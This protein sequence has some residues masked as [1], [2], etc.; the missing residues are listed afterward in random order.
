MTEMQLCYSLLWALQP[1]GSWGLQSYPMLRVSLSL[2]LSPASGLCS[3]HRAL[4]CQ[5]SAIY[6]VFP[7]LSPKTAIPSQS[8]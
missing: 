1:C 8:P 5:C 4:S 2:F 6:Q 3:H 7:Y